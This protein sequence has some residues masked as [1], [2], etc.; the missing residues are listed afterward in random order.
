M[1]ATHYLGLTLRTPLV[2]GACGPLTEDLSHLRQLEDAGASAIVLHSLFEEQIQTD[3]L[4]LN[5][6]LNQGTDSYAEALTYFPH[7]SL[8]HVSA[9]A[10]LDHIR[11]AKTMVDIPIIASLN[12]DSPGGWTDYAQMIESAGADALELNLYAVPTDPNQT[13]A[14]LEQAYLDIVRSVTEAIQIPVAV[15]LSP[16]FTNVANMAQRLSQTG[17]DGLV[18]FNRFYQPDID[19]DSLEAYPHVLLSTPQDLRLPL[20]WIAILYGRLPVDFAAT[21][22]VHQ[23]Q[24]AIKLLMAGANVTMMV[25]ALLRHGIDHLRTVEQDMQDWLQ[26]NDYESIQQLQGSM[27][28]LNCPDPSAYERAQYI[29]SIQTYRPIS[30]HDHQPSRYFG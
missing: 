21:G 19:I 24:D 8:F 6:Y 17:A 16:Y 13:A 23:A 27:S 28:Q 20:R 7:Q 11:Q 4:E 5:H 9:E 25:S 22:G 1:L 26:K 14:Q 29:K 30:V 15:K 12:G 10:Y 2:V 3:R 18:L